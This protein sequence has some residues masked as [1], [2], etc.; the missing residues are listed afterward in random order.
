MLEKYVNARMQLTSALWIMFG[1]RENLF[2]RNMPTKI[3]SMRLEL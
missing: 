2:Y 1:F 3:H